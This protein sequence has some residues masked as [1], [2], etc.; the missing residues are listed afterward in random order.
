MNE[1]DFGWLLGI[2]E[3]EGSFVLRKAKNKYAIQPTIRVCSTDKWTIDKLNEMLPAS[4]FQ[5]SRL[6]ASGKTAHYWAMSK[7]VQ[8]IDLLIHIRLYMSPRRRKQ[9]D[10][11]L[12]SIK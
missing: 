4:T 6:T 1:R 11:M 10:Y 12:A 5:A 7:K 9:I 2:L 8:V 3:G